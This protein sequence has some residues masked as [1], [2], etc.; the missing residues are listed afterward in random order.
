MGAWFVAVALVA[1][2]LWYGWHWRFM[3]LSAGAVALRIF[4][5]SV[6][7]GFAGK[8]VGVLLDR[9]RLSQERGAPA[10]TK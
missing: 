5:W 7:A 2:V 1:S 4:V 9:I 10:A 8:L 3:S 6:L